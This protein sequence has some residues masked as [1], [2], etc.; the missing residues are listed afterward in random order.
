MKKKVSI[1]FIVSAAVMLLVL[2]IIP[3]HHHNGAACM[4]VER[5]EKDNSLN[6]EHTNHHDDMQHEQSCIAESDYIFNIDSRTKY[7]ISSCDDCG[8]PDHIHFFPILYLVAD[9]LLYPAE[10]ITPQPEYGEYVSFYTSA[11]ASR[12]HGLRAPPYI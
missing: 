11:E 4:I 10:T 8:N 1:L 7:K 5:C 9:F 3:H 2:S 12:L 6:D